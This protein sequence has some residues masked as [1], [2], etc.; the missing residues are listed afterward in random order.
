MNRKR[1]NSFS[2]DMIRYVKKKK[3]KELPSKPFESTSEFDKVAGN[4]LNI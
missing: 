3:K 4:Q 2:D 1:Q